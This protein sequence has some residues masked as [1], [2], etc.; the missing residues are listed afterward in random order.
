MP[1]EDLPLYTTNLGNKLDLAPFGDYEGFIEAV[2]ELLHQ[3]YETVVE[4]AVDMNP[5]VSHEI[6]RYTGMRQADDAIVEVG[7]VEE[8]LDVLENNSEREFG[9]LED[10]LF[11]LGYR[12]IPEA[13]NPIELQE[14][15]YHNHISDN[16][17]LAS[18]HLSTSYS[19]GKDKRESDEH[20]TWANRFLVE[21]LSHQEIM[22]E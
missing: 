18:S 11:R 20:Y 7:M 4:A 12:S 2:E 13:P 1:Y 21:E 10:K 14:N 9:W 22:L 19:R 15:P 17:N 3:E 16:V 5:R 6:F 8:V